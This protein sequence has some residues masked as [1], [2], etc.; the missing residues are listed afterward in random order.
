MPPAPNVDTTPEGIAPQ[1]APAAPPTP[2]I[3]VPGK[4]ATSI[5]SSMPAIPFDSLGVSPETKQ[6][7]KNASNLENGKSGIDNLWTKAGH[8]QNPVARALAHMGVGGLKVADSVGG[9]FFPEFA[10]GIPGTQA[11]HDYL[12]RTNEGYANEAINRESDQ[13]KAV[14]EQALANQTALSPELREAQINVN[15]QK[16]ANQLDAKERSLNVQ[17]AKAGLRV[18]VDSTGQ[19]ARDAAGQ[20]QFEPDTDS[21]PFKKQHLAEQLAQSTV[22]KN[23]ADID[24]KAAETELKKAG[25]DP[26]SPT[27]K[28]AWARVLTARQNAAAATERAQAYMGNYMKGAFGTDLQGNVL[29]GQTQIDDGNG[30]LTTVGST[31]A[32]LATK[33]IAKQA[34]F[35]DTRQVVSHLRDAGH[36]LYQS[37]GS[38][39]SPAVVAALADPQTTAQMWLQGQVKNTLTPQERNAV[40]AVKAAQE[41][42]MPLRALVGSGVSDA[43]VRSLQQTLPDGSTPDLETFDE[44]MSSFD[45]QF[46]A[47]EKGI[48]KINRGGGAHAPNPANVPAGSVQVQFPSGRTTFIPAANLTQFLNDVPGATAVK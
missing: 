6:T 38:F 27:Y 45:R 34:S 35:D 40:I 44:K 41:G 25:N 33:A 19:V 4:N 17:A 10:A 32:P 5:A 22:A 7:V 23:K 36:A 30:G 12:T 43:Q 15:A 39:S 37:G 42:V 16:I 24:L 18:K 1:P 14:N 47:L 9:A 29:P 20:I 28:L 8:I 13:A 2:V 31:A 26:N 48:P 3:P 21:L 11:H 46:K